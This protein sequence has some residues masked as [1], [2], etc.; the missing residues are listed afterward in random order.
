MN[1]VRNKQYDVFSIVCIMCDMVANV[2]RITVRLI[3]LKKKKIS[4]QD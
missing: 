3:Q 4:G 2:Q 1:H